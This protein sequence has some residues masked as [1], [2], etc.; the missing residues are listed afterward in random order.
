[1]TKRNVFVLCMMLL[2]LISATPGLVSAQTVD[3]ATQK[4]PQTYRSPNFIVHS[5]VTPEAAKELL[6]RLE[7]MLTLISAYWGQRNRKTI[8][9]F[10]VD[11]L[12]NWPR[13]AI[14]AEAMDSIL[15]NA[16]ITI[17]QG[18][19]NGRQ[20]D[21]NAKVYAVADAGVPQHEAV[22]AYCAQTFGTTGPVWYSEGM[23]EMGMYWK[24]GDSSVN[25][26]PIVIDYLK[27]SE[28]KS[29]NEIVNGQ[30]IT[31]DS[32]QNYAWRWALCHLLA[33]NTNYQKRFRPLGL[34]ILQK[35]G[36]TF[37]Q[38]YGSMADE[39][40]FE[41]LLFLENMQSGYR[42][43]L[44]SWNWKARPRVLKGTRPIKVDVE[45]KSGWQPTKAQLTKG[46]EYEFTTDGTWTT[47]ENGDPVNANGDEQ[48]VGKLVGI[49]FNDY[50]LSEE[51]EI[52]VYGKFT[53]PADGH[54]FVRCKDEWGTIADNDGEI[55]FQV[56]PAAPDAKPLPMPGE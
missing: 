12:K 45:A 4:G 27:K 16:G 21:M 39:I 36:T 41:Y 17:A 47:L 28:P 56:R 51:F 42:I 1:M 18:I 53:A 52:G 9:C 8:E 40:I 50:K 31:G 32:W 3:P 54:L 55:E 35:K 15:G 20:F 48:G 19:T 44:C 13:G 29:L 14:P 37:E 11:D 5:D 30:E 46:E 49:L 10:V 2:V 43:D 26:N 34:A 6:E 24:Q 33:N 22:H 38:I 7:T 25:A 23:A